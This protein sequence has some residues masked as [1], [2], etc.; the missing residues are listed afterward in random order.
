MTFN[1]ADFLDIGNA[2]AAEVV[3]VINNVLPGAASTQGGLVV[4]NSFAAFDP[5]LSTNAAKLGLDTSPSQKSSADAEP[6]ALSPGDQLVISG[7]HNFARTVTFRSD[8]FLNIA[9]AT[10]GEVAAVLNSEVPGLASASSGQVLLAP[11]VGVDRTAGGAAI[12]LG[13]GAADESEPTVFEDAANNLWLFWSSRRSGDWKIWFSRFDGTSWGAPKQLTTGALPDR[14]PA[15]LFDS[16]SGRIWVFWSRKKAN[17]LW[18]IFFRKTTKLDFNTL[19]DADWSESE[20]SPVPADPP[21]SYNNREPAPAQLAADSLELYF[22]SD[23][24]NG[25]N[26]WSKPLSSV[27]QGADLQVTSGQF[28]RRSPAPL[29][30]GANEVTVLFRSNKT[31]IYT[32][33]LYRSAQTVDA[34]YSGSTTADTRNPARLSLRRNIRDIQ[35][36]TYHAPPQNPTLTPAELK[37]LEENRLYSRDTVG[38]YLVPDTSD[39]ELI[40]RNRSLIAE[41]LPKF[42]PIQVRLVFL[43]DQTFSELVYD[44]E[45]NG[46][47]APLIGEQMTDVLLGEAFDAI[48]DSHVDTANFKFVRTLAPGVTGGG[49]PDL[50]IHPPDL[51]FRMPITGVGEGA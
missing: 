20:L 21:G 28:T 9:A 34:R 44:Y 14:E 45:G 24:S 15:A 31:Q 42:L 40:L 17:G 29:V 22:S 47:A 50:S 27:N 36:Y 49:L 35:R 1:P 23:R 41:S 10:A 2:R 5:S 30:T 3:A 38:V 33:N 8:E 48:T 46:A 18:N 25:W 26:T 11:L 43:I 13:L 32:S 4:L 12:Q 16:A 6:F 39:E 19:A 51:S 37:V 7:K